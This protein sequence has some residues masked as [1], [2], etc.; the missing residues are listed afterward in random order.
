M[1]EREETWVKENRNAEHGDQDKRLV[2]QKS[3][4]EG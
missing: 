4:G 3:T 1:R 2:K